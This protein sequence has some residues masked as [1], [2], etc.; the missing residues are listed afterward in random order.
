MAECDCCNTN[1]PCVQG[2]TTFVYGI[3]TDACCVCRSLEWCDECAIDCARC[4]GDGEITS[5][6]G[7]FG[8]GRTET[9]PECNGSGRMMP[10]R[11]TVAR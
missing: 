5:D 4:H 11:A 7:R 1:R 9:C 10:E 8:P 6:A 3:E 2:N